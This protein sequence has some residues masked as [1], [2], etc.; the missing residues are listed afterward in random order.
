MNEFYGMDFQR[1]LIWV[2]FF[3]CLGL[4]IGGVLVFFRLKERGNLPA[5]RL[6]QYYLVMMYAYGFYGMWGE[7]LLQFLFPLEAEEAFMLKIS[8]FLSLLGIPFLLIGLATLVFWSLRMQQKRSPWLIAAGSSLALVLI[9]LPFWI[10]VPFSVLEHTEQLFAW[11]TVSGVA[12]A[13]IQLAFAHIRYMQGQTKQGLVFALLLLGVLQVPVLLHY[14]VVPEP[15]IIFIF[16]LINTVLGGYFIY[17]SEFPKLEKQSTNTLSW[18]GFVEKYGITPREKE[19]IQEIYQGKT[20]KEIADTLFVTLQT[21]KDHTHRIYQKAE[22]R[23]R[24]QLTS[25]L[26]KLDNQ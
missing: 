1:L 17:A 6:L 4:T 14:M 2:C 5:V 13:A 7:V 9:S 10:V 26:R 8:N 15:I 16:F 25:L 23:N 19:V 12:F 24:H 21:I 11:L 18:D 20:N 3:F 22:V